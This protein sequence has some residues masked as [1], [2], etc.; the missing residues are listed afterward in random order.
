M[1]T[2]DKR[3]KGWALTFPCTVTACDLLCTDE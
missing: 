1:Y 2:T 3:L